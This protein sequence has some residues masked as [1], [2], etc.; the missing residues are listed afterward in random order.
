VS[1]SVLI[2]GITGQDGAYLAEF[3]LNKGYRVIG[4]FR[5]ASMVNIARLDALG[6]SR[7]VELVPF[8]LTD[9]GNMRRTIDRFNPQEVYNLAAQSFVEVSFEQPITTG[10][11]TG[12]GAVRLLE[13]IREI[14]PA[15]RFYQASTSEMFGNAQEVPQGEKTPFYPRSPYA[16]AKL[17]AHWMT[18]NYREAYGMH[19]S[20]GILFNHECLSGTTPVMVR[21]NGL[22]GVATPDELVPLHRGGPSEQTFAP[23]D[24][25]EVWDGIR[26][27]AVGAITATRRRRIDP[28]HRLLL[29]Q[30]DGGIAEVTAHHHM[31]DAEGVKAPA[32]HVDCGTRLLLAATFPD[33]S[34]LGVLNKGLAELLGLL[35]AEG[36]IVPSDRIQFTNSDPE[37][38]ARVAEL[39]SKLFSG[40][41]AQ[42]TGV[43][44][45]N[46][47]RAVGQLYLNG[48]R[49]AGRWVR[50]QLYN[51]KGAKRVPPLVLNATPD[52][53][54]AYLSGYYAGGGLQAVTG[55]CVKTDSAL[56]A[57]GLCW[58]YANQGCACSVY[59]EQRD[60]STYYQ[61][62]IGSGH[63]V[64]NKGQDLRKPNGEVRRITDSTTPDEWVFDFETN[65][66]RF[67]A[68][69][70]RLVVHNSPLRGAEFVTRKI[71]L[72]SARIKHGLQDKL[73][74]GNLDAKRDWGYAKEYVEAMWLM[75]QQTEPE[76]YVIATGETHSVRAFV[77]AAFEA[78]GLNPWERYV[79]IDPAFMRPAEVSHLRGAPHKAKEKLGWEPKTAFRELVSLM[80]ES[81]LRQAA[82][83]ARHGQKS[84]EIK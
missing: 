46:S 73:K 63:G 23:E 32:R 31:L 34:K 48:A 77:E 72:A 71:T 17:Y 30:A 57:Q 84:V 40:T 75:M 67:C 11:I 36:Y 41:A 22:V 8:D 66:G 55:E 47:E 26:W 82:F 45:W 33:A 65:S 79:V 9:H 39:W 78:A 28:D 64:G 35:T 6:I 83:E 15:I 10:D 53:Q 38:C 60:G 7:D 58:L 54:A 25:V 18:V 43:S 16:A 19:A 37:L 42:G 51:A 50:E 14:N 69:V 29:V 20:S 56:L 52:A 13:V 24:P 1:K 68:G 2:T 76:D 27:T 61:L 62:N 21:R 80:V 5:R 44:G 59:A 49:A 74:L 70:G 12:V 3:L 81:D 4:A